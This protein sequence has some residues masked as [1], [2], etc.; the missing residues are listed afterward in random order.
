MIFHESGYQSQYK[1]DVDKALQARPQP[2]SM[3]G[4]IVAA[5]HYM[6]TVRRAQKATQGATTQR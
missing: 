3:I 6:R 2:L 4:R 5:S 1:G